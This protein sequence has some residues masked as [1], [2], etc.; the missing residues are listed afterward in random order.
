MDRLFYVR[1]LQW[2]SCVRLWH[3]ILLGRTVSAMRVDAN[4]WMMTIPCV[5][6]ERAPTAEELASLGV[7]VNQ[8]ALWAGPRTVRGLEETGRKRRSIE[9][10]RLQASTYAVGSLFCVSGSDILIFEREAHM[11]LFIMASEHAECCPGLYTPLCSVLE[12]QRIARSSEAKLARFNATAEGVRRA[13]FWRPMVRIL[14]P[15]AESLT[16]N[17]WDSER[18]GGDV[19][20]EA[21][22]RDLVI[23]DMRAS[24]DPV[25]FVQRDAEGRHATCMMVIPRPSR[26]S[27]GSGTLLLVSYVGYHSRKA[28]TARS[29]MQYGEGAYG[30]VYS[31]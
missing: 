9:M 20:I 28:D 31:A 12:V 30:A 11:D 19:C 17:Q 18:Y 8:W 26:W 3:E 25:I 29:V 1:F 21:L 23:D 10:R 16:L 6:L 15:A 14:W 4:E 27:D 24:L 5:G 2:H 7:L 22:M 13:D